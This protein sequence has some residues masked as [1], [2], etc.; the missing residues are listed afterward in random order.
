MSGSAM[1]I[2]LI[3]ARPRLAGIRQMYKDLIGLR[4]NLGGNTAGLAG[5]HV[6]VFH[7]QQ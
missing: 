2:R 1:M 6:N 7:E 3:G 4:R 5:P